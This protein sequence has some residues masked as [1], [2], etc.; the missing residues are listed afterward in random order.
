MNE[1]MNLI[2]NK[3]E[4]TRT[5]YILYVEIGINQHYNHVAMTVVVSFLY[6]IG[7]PEHA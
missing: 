1:N 6:D 5:D 4:L 2:Q 3:W 7:E